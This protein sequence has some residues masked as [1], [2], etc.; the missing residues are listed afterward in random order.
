MPCPT[1]PEIRL[2]LWARNGVQQMLDEFAPNAVH[3]AT[4]GPIGWMTRRYCKK[5]GVPFTT[6]SD[7]HTPEAL[8]NHYV[9]LRTELS[10]RGITEVSAFD[11]RV[12]R[13]VSV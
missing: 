12:R 11:A 4:E 8:G 9:D 13:A 1:Y 5:R 7:G 6:A 2:A 3:I 10:S